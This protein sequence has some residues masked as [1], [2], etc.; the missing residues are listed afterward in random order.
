MLQSANS[1]STVTRK[2]KPVVPL[3]HRQE[4]P[5][6]QKL[7]AD[8]MAN[9][10]FSPIVRTLVRE[11]VATNKKEATELI[12][13]FAQWYATGSVTKT[14]SYVMFVGEVDE[15]LHAMILNSKWYMTFC[16]RTTGVYTHHEPIGET[17]LKDDEVV[18]AAMFTARLLERTWGEGLSVYLKG[19]VENAKHGTS[20]ASSV[21]C[22]GNDGPF[23]IVPIEDLREA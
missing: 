12:K 16:Y 1:P 20:L 19:H 11:R 4:C 9:H 6:A 8:I 18:E 17:G 15:V 7:F 5:S 13:A 21:S 2:G 14:K 3:K 23:D 10:D 22:V